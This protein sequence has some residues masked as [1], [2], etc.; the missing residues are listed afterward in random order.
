MEEGREG[1]FWESSGLTR[2]IF[3]QGIRGLGEG[4]MGEGK[5]H[6]DFCVHKPLVL[7]GINSPSLTD[8]LELSQRRQRNLPDCLFW[9]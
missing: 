4:K 5:T 9:R 1:N 3:I 8:Q 2:V 6:I 7:L